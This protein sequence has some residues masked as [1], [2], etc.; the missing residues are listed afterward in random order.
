MSDERK[1]SVVKGVN[2]KP[3]KENG[4]QVLLV[5]VPLLQK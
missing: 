5:G 1:F 2:F 3:E 4:V